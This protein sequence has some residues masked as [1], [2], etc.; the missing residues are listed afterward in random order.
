MKILKIFLIFLQLN[1][2][3]CEKIECEFMENPFTLRYVC[4]MTNIFTE[5]VEG[6]SV[7]GVEKHVDGFSNANVTQLSTHLFNI[8]PPSPKYYPIKMCNLL[9]SLTHIYVSSFEVVT[10]EVFTNCQKLKVIFIMG[11]ELKKIDEDLFTDAITV[12]EITF[13][14]TNLEFLP[15][16]LFKNNPA[17]TSVNLRGNHELKVIESEF[18]KNLTVLSVIGNGC[19]DEHY[20]STEPSSTPLNQVIKKIEKNC[21]N[22]TKSE[23]QPV[24]ENN[25]EF[26]IDIL[27]TRTRWVQE[28]ELKIY[29]EVYEKFKDINEDLNTF[30]KLR[31]QLMQGNIKEI[32]KNVNG[33]IRKK[34]QNITENFEKYQEI[35]EEISEIN[36]E[37][38]ANV[39]E[40]INLSEENKEILLKIDE[41]EYLIFGLFVIQL[42]TFSIGGII[43]IYVKIQ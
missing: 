4:Y 37:M 15:K 24:I 43:M 12:E 7:V 27:T 42:A 22:S 13:F 35:I 33:E 26:R 18:P 14:V 38:E 20:N 29:N 2:H 19:I 10:R 31:I 9:S 25:N 21:K 39:D 8:N 28:Y 3:F 34:I 11:N 1:L 6:T 40:M 32:H 16:N 5:L 41:N 23:I 30:I 36:R 17:L